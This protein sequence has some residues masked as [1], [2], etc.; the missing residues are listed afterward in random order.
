MPEFIKDWWSVIVGVFTLIVWL[1]R[2]EGK[3][4]S[5]SSE[6]ESIKS[7]RKE[8]LELRRHDQTQTAELLKEIRQDIKTL[9][10]SK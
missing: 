3:G 4:L 8:D 2:L 1:V 7:Q 5:N 9:M 6:I 10:A